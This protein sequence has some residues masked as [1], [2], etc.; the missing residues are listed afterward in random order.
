[1][2][3]VKPDLLTVLRQVVPAVFLILAAVMAHARQTPPGSDVPPDQVVATVDG[4][5]VTEGDLELLYLSRGVRDE[6]KASVRDRYIDDLIDRLLLRRFLAGQQIQ[7]SRAI[8]DERVQRM[9]KLVTREGLDFSETLQ[10]LGYT[11]ATFRETV[12]QPI[13]WNIHARRV[14]TDEAVAAY[15]NR[16]QSRFD[17]T[18]VRAAQIVKRIP[19]DATPEQIETLRRKL[20]DLRAKILAGSISFADAARNESDSPSGQDGGDI[21]QFVYRGRMPVELTSVAFSLKPAEISEPF[22]TRFGM[23]LMTVTEIIPG[24]LSLE[25]ARAE[26]F[27]VLSRKLQ[28]RLIADLRKKAVIRKVTA[29]HQ[30]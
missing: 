20:E 18:E 13:V 8:V 4:E 28:Q 29:G 9:E 15:W 24:D 30:G 25:D 7:A 1:M 5:P 21:G 11:R 10:S 23:H 26:I 22:R 17:G 27:G 6:L 12:E 2:L 3:T 19:A 14:I 16:H